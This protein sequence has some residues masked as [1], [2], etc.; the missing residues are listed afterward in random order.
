MNNFHMVGEDEG[1][2]YEFIHSEKEPTQAVIEKVEEKVAEVKVEPTV[3]RV[4]KTRMEIA[5]N[6]IEEIAKAHGEEIAEVW[7]SKID[8][9]T[10]VKEW[11]VQVRRYETKS[12]YITPFTKEE[13]AVLD[14]QIETKRK[15]IYG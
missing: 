6:A 15:E 8:F 10:E 9:N 5:S 4:F 12:K 13:W 14:K 2:G 11:V 3:E 1:K 7:G